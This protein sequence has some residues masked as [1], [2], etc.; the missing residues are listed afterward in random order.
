MTENDFSKL[1][2]EFM[3]QFAPDIGP[4]VITVIDKKTCDDIHRF[5]ALVLCWLGT[6][7]GKVQKILYKVF[8]NNHDS[9]VRISVPLDAW[10]VGCAEMTPHKK[11][12]G[13]LVF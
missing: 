9:F 10:P 13:K 1:V 7:N 3:D 4:C 2:Y 11:H 12:S 8:V 6:E 5:T